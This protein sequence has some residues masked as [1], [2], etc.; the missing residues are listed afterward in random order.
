MMELEEW[1]S[2]GFRN[3]WILVE[4]GMERKNRVDGFITC[5]VVGGSLLLPGRISPYGVLRLLLS[6]SSFSP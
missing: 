2:Y 4:K 6:L 1:E 3:R 5:A